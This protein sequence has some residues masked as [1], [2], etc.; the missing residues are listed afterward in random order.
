MVELG[1]EGDENNED[2]DDLSTNGG[3]N[4][5]FHTPSDSHWEQQ[6]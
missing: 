5:V 3:G 6:R 4:I 2:T 1:P